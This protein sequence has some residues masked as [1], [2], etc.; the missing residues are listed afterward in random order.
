[1]K[2]VVLVLGILLGVAL[3]QA[4]VWIPVVRSWRRTR[5]AW[6]TEVHTE[7]LASG[8]HTVRGPERASYR[9]GSG[10]FSNVKGIG[11]LLLTDRRVL[12]RKTSGGVVEIERSA[13]VG[14]RRAT[15]FNGSRVAGQT[16]LVVQVAGAEAGFIVTDL[17]TWEQLLT[18][19][20]R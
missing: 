15:S 18:P 2:V 14:T 6:T 16:V 13:I 20:P 4:L 17:D 10:S 12:F 3:I 1:M 19:P 11:V 7:M 8:E 5:E 9:G